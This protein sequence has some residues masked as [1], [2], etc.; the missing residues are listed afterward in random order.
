MHPIICQIGPFT[1]YSYGVMLTVAVLVCSFLI[2]KEA[3]VRGLPPEKMLDLVF[4][5][6]VGGIIGARLFYI[7]LN[8]GFYWDNPLEMLMLWHGGLAF[9]GGLIVGFL[10]GCYFIRK[11]SLPFLPTL[12]LLAPYVALGHAIGRL[13]CFLNGCCYGKE[14]A[15][16]IGR[17]HV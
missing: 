16:E 4:W 15:W 10:S 3:K 9:Q 1:V 5:V 13:G 14:V 17:A 7:L 2:G 6:V 12:D 11:N 8:A